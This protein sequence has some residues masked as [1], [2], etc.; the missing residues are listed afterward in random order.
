MSLVNSVS[1]IDNFKNAIQFS[2]WC[3]LAIIYI[4]R[5][6]L[7]TFRLSFPD[8][9]GKIYLH[10]SHWHYLV[11]MD[12]GIKIFN[13]HSWTYI[14]GLQCTLVIHS[15]C[16]IQTWLS[17]FKLICIQSFCNMTKSTSAVLSKFWQSIT[18]LLSV[19]YFKKFKWKQSG[20]LITQSI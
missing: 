14:H 9:H 11:Q 6:S 17:T 19:M 16:I 5:A 1:F 18:H 4:Y 7:H 2:V 3:L 10:I 15:V 8:F 13:I 12:T 20:V